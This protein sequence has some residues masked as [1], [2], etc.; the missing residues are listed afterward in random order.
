MSRQAQEANDDDDSSASLS[1][2]S[3]IC[4]ARV[5]RSP[6]FAPTDVGHSNYLQLVLMK[7]RVRRLRVAGGNSILPF[8]IVSSSRNIEFTLI[9]SKTPQKTSASPPRGV[10]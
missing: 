8:T 9:E 5:R 2:L 3:S 7:F 4:A 10:C 6:M 1:L